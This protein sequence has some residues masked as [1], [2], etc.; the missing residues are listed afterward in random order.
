MALPGMWDWSI[1]TTGES[2]S[3]TARPSGDRLW[4]SRQEKQIPALVEGRGPS[5]WVRL[6]AIEGSRL[7]N[8]FLLAADEGLAPY[9]AFLD[10]EPTDWKAGEWR[11]LRYRIEVGR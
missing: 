5:G 11:V 10:G 6:Q 9:F 7:Q 3:G 1:L 8:A 4:Q 2:L